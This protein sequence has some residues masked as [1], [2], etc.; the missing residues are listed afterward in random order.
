[1]GL[2]GIDACVM[3]RGDASG[4]YDMLTMGLLGDALSDVE[5]RGKQPT[6]NA[7]EP[8]ACRT[9][10]A[11]GAAAAA[12]ALLADGGVAGAGEPP[13][14]APPACDA[15]EGRYGLVWMYGSTGDIIA[16]AVAR[17]GRCGDKAGNARGGAA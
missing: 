6:R 9:D 17:G 1:M 2:T 8:G 7:G 4:L 13:L 10:T 15:N 12:T 14:P 3:M 5:R 16:G 11:N